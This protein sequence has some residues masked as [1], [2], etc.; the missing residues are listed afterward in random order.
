MADLDNTLFKSGRRIPLED[1]DTVAWLK[2]DG[3]PGGFMN[4][5]QTKFWNWVNATGVVCP[6]TA[7]R[8]SAFARVVLPFGP[9]QACNFGAIIYKNGIEDALWTQQGA[10]FA[11]ESAGPLEH[12]WDEALAL[13]SQSF[14]G[15]PLD[16]SVTRETIDGE[17]LYISIT[18][19][20]QGAYLPLLAHILRGL[21]S[22]SQH[23]LV[24]SNKTVA[25]TP[26]WLNK[27]RAAKYIRDKATLEGFNTFIGLGD[28][29]NDLEFMQVCDWGMYPNDSQIAKESLNWA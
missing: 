28:N 9:W 8:P 19:K 12:L 2:V 6:I 13:A 25:L 24:V 4:G 29:L 15:G 14:I 17:L 3:T 27:Q 22:G 18:D 23:T 26:K 5:A 1:R 10:Q 16:L 21:D 11:S 7:R 20:Q